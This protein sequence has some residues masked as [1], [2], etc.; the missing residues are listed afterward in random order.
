MHRVFT[1]LWAFGLAALVSL[2]VEG[3]TFRLEDG[4][5]FE[6]TPV[7]PPEDDGLII[8]LNVGGFSKR[9][10]WNR[11]DQETLKEMV[12]D[13]RLRNFV[14]P[15][16]DLTPEQ[17]ERTLPRRNQPITI[18]EVP[19]LERPQNPGFFSALTTT[20]GLFFFAIFYL[21]NLFAAYEVAA[22]R[23]RPVLVVL[24]VCAVVPVIG[25]IV[26]LSL[27]SMDA[28]EVA[29]AHEPAA[30]HSIEA[31]A[32]APASSLGLAAVKETSNP[33]KDSLEGSVFKKADVTFD[34][35]FF[36]VRFAG[37]FRVNL[38]EPEK[39]LSIVVRASGKEI[40]AARISRISFNEVAFQL[41]KGGESSVEFAEIQEVLVRKK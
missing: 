22:F 1:C 31:T 25:Q 21:A 18:R 9:I 6:G 14:E 26:F 3:A 35:R 36:E 2:S 38:S 40:V 16:I 37:F 11:F 32:A 7:V 34:R 27:P 33:A 28:P 13:A 29:T 15:F 17:F 5:V 12:K 30:G 8:Q 10:P 23:R 4:D 24:G 20:G 39:F 19:R 41:V